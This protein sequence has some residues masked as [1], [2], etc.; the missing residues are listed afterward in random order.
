MLPCTSNLISPFLSPT[1]HPPTSPTQLSCFAFLSL[2]LSFYS[3]LLCCI[4]VSVEKGG[5]QGR[6][7]GKKEEGG[8]WAPKKG[9]WGKRGK[10]GPFLYENA[11]CWE[12][13]EENPSM[14]KAV[15]PKHKPDL[16]KVRAKSQV[17]STAG[18]CAPPFLHLF[19]FFHDHP[20]PV[21]P[22]SPPLVSPH[23]FSKACL[24]FVRQLK[25]QKGLIK[26][27]DSNERSR[28]KV[29]HTIWG[30][31]GSAVWS[32]G[33]EMGMFCCCV[34]FSVTL[35]V[36]TEGSSKKERKKG[37]CAAA[38]LVPHVWDG[39]WLTQRD[40]EGQGESRG[41]RGWWRGRKR[42][43]SLPP[44]ILWKEKQECRGSHQ[45]TRRCLDKPCAYWSRSQH[46]HL[47]A[48]KR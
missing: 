15:G 32:C 47:Q 38:K 17:F 33:N 24:V 3:L 10:E 23:L 41:E 29:R 27:L 11:F 46:G 43:L 2:S 16:W 36:S 30:K 42:G 6:G 48:S 19:S 31:A 9:G 8:T 37:I 25:T 26:V 5:G 21:F 34:F 22:P 40:G 35:E 20:L 12:C 44:T 13:W 28:E 39:N 14:T 7:R 4:P 1:P 18:L 45:E